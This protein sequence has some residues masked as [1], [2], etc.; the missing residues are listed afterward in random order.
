MG[1]KRVTAIVR[2]VALDRP[3]V[4]SYTRKRYTACCV[5]AYGVLMS[6]DKLCECVLDALPAGKSDLA[7]H[8][9]RY[10]GD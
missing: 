9:T 2:F 5:E 3:G 10:K 6:A 7:I 4:L 8:A 1:S